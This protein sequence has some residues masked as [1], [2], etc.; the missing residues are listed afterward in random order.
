M[1]Q[2]VE[3]SDSRSDDPKFEPSQELTKNLRGCHSQTCYADSLSV[4]PT[5]RTHVKDP[6]VHV[7]VLWIAETR[8][9]PACT[10]L[11]EG[12]M[13][14]CTEKHKNCRFGSGPLMKIHC[15]F[16]SN[17]PSGLLNHLSAYVQ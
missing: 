12:S 2:L 4:C 5:P 11:T 8:K 14:L 6:V 9:N 17:G 3:G 1:A 10:L 13:C 15:V 7:R 16:Y